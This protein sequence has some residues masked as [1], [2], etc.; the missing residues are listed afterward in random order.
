MNE[1]LSCFVMK[2]A[3][4][5][6]TSKKCEL[7]DTDFTCGSVADLPGLKSG[8]IGLSSSAEG[9]RENLASPSVCWCMELPVLNRKIEGATDCVCRDCLSK[10]IAETKI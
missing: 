5:R 6:M 4:S 7:C 8:E 10:L 3:D 1:V 9:V 2:R